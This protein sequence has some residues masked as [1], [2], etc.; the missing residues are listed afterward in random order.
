M[1]KGHPHPGARQDLIISN[2]AHIA[3]WILGLFELAE[4]SSKK[5]YL[6]VLLRGFPAPLQRSLL[7]RDY[8]T[9]FKKYAE[10]WRPRKE[11]TI[12]TLYT[13]C[14]K[15]AGVWYVGKADASRLRNNRS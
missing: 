9:D 11:P 6:R 5:H 13:V 12:A 2:F 3:N 1:V 8:D 10:I 14:A 15:E 4:F 7:T